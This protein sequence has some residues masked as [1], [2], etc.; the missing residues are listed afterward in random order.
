MQGAV[1]AAEARPGQAQ[2][3]LSAMIVQ[4]IK[5]NIK[6]LLIAAKGCGKVGGGSQEKLA[7]PLALLGVEP[8]DHIALHL[9]LEPVNASSRSF[10]FPGQPDPDCAPVAT[11]GLPLDKAQSR[12]SRHSF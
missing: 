2:Q 4:G 12:Q 8:H 10:A 11:S 1:I 6:V 9:I 7:Q 5:R 3:T